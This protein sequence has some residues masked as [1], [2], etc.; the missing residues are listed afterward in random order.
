MLRRAA[1]GHGAVVTGVELDPGLAAAAR[2]LL[3]AEGVQGAVVEA[4]FETVPIDADVVFAFLSPATLQRLRARLG[5]LDAG[6]R[7]VTTGYA[8]PGW[9]PDGKRG[10]IWLYR[11]P[12]TRCEPEPG[13]RGW[14]GAGV[15]VTVRPDAPALVAVKLHHAGG[16]VGVSAGGQGDFRG[17]AAV[18]TGADVAAPGDEVIVDVRFEARPAGTLATGTLDAAGEAPFHV[19]A[20]VDDGEPV[21]RGLSASGCEVVA[22]AFAHGDLAPVLAAAR[23]GR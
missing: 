1:A 7:V 10:R 14:D 3:A 20:A 17:W 6:T 13:A 18:R 19:F 16:P 12:P 2:A 5:A 9:R 15:L 8:M 11:M 4:D 21:V 23:D 22:R